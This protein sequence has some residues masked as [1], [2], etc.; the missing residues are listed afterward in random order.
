MKA[1]TIKIIEENPVA[2]ATMDIQDNPYVI[3]VSSVKVKNDKIVITDNYMKTTLENIKKN[4]SV[5]LIVWNSKLKGV[6]IKGIAEYFQEGEWMK[7]IKQIPENKNE[8]CKGALVINI[9]NTKEIN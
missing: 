2:F 4:P 7:F 5:S 1:E 3:A 9:K 6:Q 8:P